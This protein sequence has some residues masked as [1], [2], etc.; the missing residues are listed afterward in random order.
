MPR[1]VT[2][3]LSFT[4]HHKQNEPTVYTIIRSTDH[5]MSYITHAHT[6]DHVM[7]YIAQL[8][9]TAFDGI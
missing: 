9:Q 6:H 4:S 7:S 2:S 8:Q 3:S 1:M 5:V